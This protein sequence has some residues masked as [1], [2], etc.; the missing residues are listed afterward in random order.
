MYTKWTAWIIVKIINFPCESDT[1]HTHGG[2]AG[3]ITDSH[4]ALTSCIFSLCKLFQRVPVGQISSAV[5]AGNDHCLFNMV[6]TL[7]VQFSGQ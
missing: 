1:C 7:T 3:L 6:K 4:L 5:S 2:I